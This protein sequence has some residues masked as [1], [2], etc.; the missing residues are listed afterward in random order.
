MVLQ[1]AFEG[2]FGGKLMG[3]KLT[4][5]DGNPRRSNDGAKLNVLL[6]ESEGTKYGTNDCVLDGYLDGI[7]I[8]A[9]LGTIDGDIVGSDDCLSLGS[10][11]GILLGQ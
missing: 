6:T 8:G 7:V 4:T 1:K 10:S 2:I 3:T 11:L 9:E 5:I